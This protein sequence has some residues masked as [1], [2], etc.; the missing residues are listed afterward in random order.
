MLHSLD[1]W[2]ITLRHFFKLGTIFISLEL[3]KESLLGQDKYLTKHTV[4]KHS[5]YRES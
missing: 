1:Y 2:L 3:M 5:K 4:N